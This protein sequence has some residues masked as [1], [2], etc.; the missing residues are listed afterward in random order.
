MRN[1]ENTYLNSL[2]QTDKPRL[3]AFLYIIFEIRKENNDILPS[4]YQF[5]NKS[6]LLSGNIAFEESESFIKRALDI[7]DAY[8]RCFDYLASLRLEEIESLIKT[9]IYSFF[10]Q[11]KLIDKDLELLDK[12]LYKGY[13]GDCLILSSYVKDFL[14]TDE[15]VKSVTF[16]FYSFSVNLLSMILF[17]LNGINYRYYTGSTIELGLDSMYDTIF[18]FPPY[19]NQRSIQEI[20]SSEKM[21]LNV[22]QSFEYRLESNLIS[23][24]NPDGKILSLFS[25]GILSKS[26]DNNIKKRLFEKGLIHMIVELPRLQAF[27]F[28]LSYIHARRGNK[29]IEV[30]NATK[31]AQNIRRGINLD[32]ER[33]IR[34]INNQIEGALGLMSKEYLEKNE[35]DLSPHKFF[36]NSLTDFHNPLML[37]DLVKSIYRGFQIPS[38]MLDE[39]L[40]IK[41]T[42]IKL[43]TLSDIEDGQI[44]KESLQSLKGID[45]KMEH[46]I[47]ENNDLVISCKGKTFKTAVLNIP[48][49]ETYISTGS[50]I[51]IRCNEEVLD[52]TF[53]KIFLD[54]KI[55]VESL[56]RIQ[57]G[58]RVLSLNPRKM[59][60][61]IVP[62]PSISRQLMISSSYKY[63]LQNIKEVKDV[64][65]KMREEMD[66]KFNDNFLSLVD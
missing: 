19:K 1:I 66:K 60:E 44:N 59:L 57:T 39:Y 37:K 48:Y 45:K 16:N 5:Q 17:E 61:I 65:Q 14:F 11:Q 12:E 33:I 43:L 36:E 40:S 56:R 27:S 18:I 35:Y 23:H 20:I 22:T 13:I 58:G 30:I 7:K 28:P 3:I 6:K 34:A 31:F 54:S 52:P 63:K 64:A 50:L 2:K 4:F 9:T 29:L 55:G 21:S 51:V 41:E 42:K 46:Y 47:L 15:S 62:T 26:A 10:D 8:S 25:T 38:E 32:S 24:L 49:S 53:L